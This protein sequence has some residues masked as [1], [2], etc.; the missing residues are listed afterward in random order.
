[1][2]PLAQLQNVGRTFTSD[3]S[4]VA[5]ALS[6][7]S[8]AVHSGALM[9][10]RGPSGCGKSTLLNLLGLLDRPTS[11]EVI[12]GGAPTRSLSDRAFSETRRRHTAFLFQDAGLIEGM[13]VRRNVALPLAY[14][15]MSD[16]Q[17]DRRTEEV[18]DDVRLLHRADARV[19]NLSGGER[20]RVGLAR[21][22][23]SEPDF[24]VCDEPTAS[25]DIEN[26]RHIIE[27]L[28]S[29]CRK[30]RGVVCS[31]HDPRLIE[32]ADEVVDLAHGRRV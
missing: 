4:G 15:R 22:M 21:A 13:S 24:L 3:G 8:L 31:S 9:V 23:A 2:L 5:I 32:A 18:L 26:G 19:N 14:R 28:R 29:E 1:M 12:V 7:V 10:I 11:G 20:Q 16:Q 30:G 6:E 17:R 27:L 25:L